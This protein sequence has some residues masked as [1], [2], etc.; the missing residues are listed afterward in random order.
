M[1]AHAL[2]H[3]QT[4]MLSNQ[5]HPWSAGR[6]NILQLHVK[7]VAD[8]GRHAPHAT[9]G[10]EGNYIWELPAAT[11]CRFLPVGLHAVLQAST[12]DRSIGQSDIR[13]V[14]LGIGVWHH[15]NT[16]HPTAARSS[17]NNRLVISFYFGH[18]GEVHGS[19]TDGEWG[20]ALGV[21]VPVLSKF[22]R[23]LWFDVT[24]TWSR[25]RGRSYRVCLTRDTA[26]LTAHR[27]IKKI[28]AL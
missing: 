11:P 3:T 22:K 16:L 13:V 7:H 27:S 24:V 9:T 4:G 18:D 23:R 26:W 10:G 28:A 12:I 15:S 17:R 1:H 6:K 8:R 20:I 21:D 5:G 14:G 25:T 19:G 2:S